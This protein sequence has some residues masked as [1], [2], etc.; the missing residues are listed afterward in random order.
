MQTSVATA[1]F[2]RGTGGQVS[3]V[4][5]SGSNQFNGSVFEY[6]RNSNM[7]AADFFTNKSNG[8]KNPLHRNQF[9]ATL[10]GP[11]WHDKTFFF[12]SW[13]DFRQVAPQV[14][15][16]RVP[17]AAERATVVDPISK[18][19][20]QF[21]P[22]AN[23]SISGS[24]NNFIA[25]VGST[26]FDHT[27]LLKIDHNFSEKDHLSGRW[28]EYEG[29]TFTPGA[30]P[31][32]DGNGNAPISRSGVLSETHTFSPKVLNEFRFGFS[33]NQ[34]FI[35]V[36]DSG[37]DASTIFK[38][39][40]GKVLPGIVNG[41]A[42]LLDSGLPTIGVTGGFASL[43]STSNLPQG[44]ITNTYELFDNVSVIAPFGA[45]KHSFRMGIHIRR[46]DA[47]RFLDGSA[48]GVFNFTSFS[49]FANGL[50]NTSSLLYGSTLD[51]WQRYPVDAYWQDTY[52]VKDNLTVNYGLRY[53]YPSAIAQTRNQATNF[54]P[55]VG[56]V[57]LGTNQLLTIDTTKTGA[58]L[59][60]KPAPNT[61]SNTGVNKDN[62]N[63]AP[64]LGLAYTPRFAPQLFGKDDTV[65][66]AGFRVGYDDLFNN[67]PANMGLN[68]PYNLTTSQ[69]AG[70]TQPGKF[71]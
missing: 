24:A 25:N 14:S 41:G 7:D 19:L 17:T 45:S 4:T 63:F 26:T 64:V 66:R 37:F 22:T 30:L 33:R 18:A 9:G 28:A 5:K 1:E 2:G 36:Q 47:R 54:V 20:L 12:A 49:D 62:N 38:D 50:V 55:G 23:T 6:F 16:T 61:L 35:T 48:R 10:G 57:L 31:L 43:G 51:Y 71:S 59:V 40:S 29:T 68:A 70:T 8:I 65:I 34:T 52:K 27:G 11:I 56:P 60:L 39:A 3:I 21:W 42:N 58:S 69:A 67:I 46:E 44:R 15:T 32:L 53:E 13:E